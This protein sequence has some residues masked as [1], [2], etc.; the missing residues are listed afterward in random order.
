MKYCR[1]IADYCSVVVFL[2]LI[3]PCF[4]QSTFTKNQRLNLERKVKSIVEAGRR[5]SGLPGVS[6]VIMRG[7]KTLLAKGYGLAD[8]EK[9]VA[10][11][12]H[13]IYPIASLSKQFTAVAIMKLVEQGRVRLDEPVSTYLP[14]YR[15]NQTTV[16]RI[17]HLLQQTSGIPE[18]NDLPEMQE[19]DTGE[20]AGFTI[21]KIIELLE[22]QPQLYQPGDWW[23]YSNSNYTLLAAVIERVS[24]MTY[25]QYLSKNFF[26][27]LG[28]QSTGDCKPERGLSP[29]LQNAIGYSGNT[30]KLK[31]L[32]ATKAKAFTGSGGMCSNAVNLAGWMRALVD[33]KA[34]S[35]ASYREMITPAPV[36]AGFTPPY[37]FGLSVVPLA[38]QPAVWHTGNLAGFTSVLIYFPKQDLIIAALTNSRH[39]PLHT[40]VKRVAS[41]VM[42][43]KEPK[44][45]DLPISA[46]K[47]N[48]IVGN[49]DD[50]M[51]KFRIYAESGRLYLHVTEF[52]EPKRLQYQ[53]DG[54]F[55]T[56]EPGMIRLWF[57]PPNGKVERVVWE[58]SEIRAYGRKIR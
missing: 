45:L 41:A 36:R 25:E 19:I 47:L 8:R 20:P 23:S 2:S 42:N 40:I 15:A 26:V 14:E 13:T 28:L 17:R 51:F 55:A 3:T 58:W 32:T 6:I 1:I 56:T 53:G 52:G 5:E 33:G 11:S 57:E 7:N 4:S 39:A 48:R 29:G 54:I 34:V 9:G 22:R 27:P 31:P 50:A 16:L 46:E 43:L 12:P 24:G 44:L 49:Y 21:T 37:G 30:F 10:T 35:A 38:N 18:W